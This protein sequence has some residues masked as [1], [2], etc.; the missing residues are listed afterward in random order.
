MRVL[1]IAGLGVLIAALLAGA[2][3]SFEAFVTGTPLLQARDTKQDADFERRVRKYLLANP[4]VLVESIQQFQARQQTAQTDD[5]AQIIGASSDEIFNDPET[6]VGGNPQGDVS[7]VEFFDYNCPYCRRVAPTL[8]E[9]ARSDPNV[10]IVY[11]EW[12]ILGPNSDFAARAALAAR[13][14]GKYVEF[15]KAMMLES[16]LMN[17]PR[18]LEVATNLGLDLERLNRDMEAPKIAA[19]LERNDGLARRLRVTGTPSFVI[20]DEVLRGAADIEVIRG[21]IRRVRKKRELR[22]QSGHGAR[23]TQRALANWSERVGSSRTT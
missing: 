23:K 8:V 2:W 11:K 1:K 16:G 21:L 19:I 22:Q 14:Q 5:I 18:V 9:I 20:G 10:R 4:E 13:T 7:L 6:P 15:H 12:P 17:E 3:L